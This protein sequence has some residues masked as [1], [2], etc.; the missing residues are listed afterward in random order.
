MLFEAA[1]CGQISDKHRHYGRVSL[2]TA[3]LS[4]S[5]KPVLA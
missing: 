4:S 2:L 5:R 1:G 3:R